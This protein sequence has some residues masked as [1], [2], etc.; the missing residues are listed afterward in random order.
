VDLRRT[1][2]HGPGGSGLSLASLE[3]DAARAGR[4]RETPA[5]P[6]YAA[7][8]C[9]RDAAATP[10][11]DAAAGPWRPVGGGSASGR[12][13]RRRLLRHRAAGAGPRDGARGRCIGQGGP[14]GN[15][16]VDRPGGVSVDRV[17]VPGARVRA[18]ATLRGS[19]RSVGRRSL[20]DGA[21]DC[22]RRGGGP[23]DVC[24]R[25]PSRGHR[26]RVGRAA[27]AAGAGAASRAAARHRIPGGRRRT[28]ARR[29]RCAGERRRYRRPG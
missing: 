24:Q 27:A 29:R 8:H 9:R 13:H 16:A 25:R 14:G 19:V 3:R 21:G 22:R 1:A 11:E 23:G 18:H 15:G 28:P 5:R 26:R 2:R 17:G 20:S 10:A 12:Q 4:A 6:R 7:G